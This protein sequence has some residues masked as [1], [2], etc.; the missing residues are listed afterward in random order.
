MVVLTTVFDGLDILPLIPVS[1]DSML[2]IPG[3]AGFNVFF[4]NMQAFGFF[5]GRLSSSWPLPG[6]NV[7]LVFIQVSVPR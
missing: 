7:F 2:L 1:L 5:R 3:L 6:Q 4:S